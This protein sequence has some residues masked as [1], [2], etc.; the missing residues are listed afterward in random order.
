MRQSSCRRKSRRR[1][2]ETG[3]NIHQQHE[4]RRIRRVLQNASLLRGDLDD[5]IVIVATSAQPVSQLERITELLCAVF[6]K[7]RS[8]SATLHACAMQPRGV[9]GGSA[10]KI[11]LIEPTHAS[12]MCRRKP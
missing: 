11:S 1:S 5:M 3:S 2:P 8:T 10:S 12:L 4:L 6:T 9:Y 7:V